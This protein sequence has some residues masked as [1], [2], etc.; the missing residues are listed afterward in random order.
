MRSL[1]GYLG[2]VCKYVFGSI[3]V[4]SLFFRSNQGIAQH[5]LGNEPDVIYDEILDPNIRT[6]QFTKSDLPNAV[7]VLELGG[8]SY[9]NLQFDVMGSKAPRNYQFTIIHCSS[10]WI[11]S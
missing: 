9:L 6:V 3:I 10:D 1:K 4:L 7:P 2:K 11:P 8:G 5:L